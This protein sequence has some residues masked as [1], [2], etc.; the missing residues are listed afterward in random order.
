LNFGKLLE[1]FLFKKIGKK[2]ASI[3]E[4]PYPGIG[5]LEAF[6]YNPSRQMVKTHK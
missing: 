2:I 1:I 3:E 6:K 5:K 4:S